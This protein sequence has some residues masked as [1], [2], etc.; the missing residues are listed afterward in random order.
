[1]KRRQLGPIRVENPTD[2]VMRRYLEI[3]VD[4][5][6]SEAELSRGTSAASR[7]AE[8]S[9]VERDAEKCDCACGCKTIVTLG[10]FSPPVTLCMNCRD[11]LV[12]RETDVPVVRR[13]GDGGESPGGE[14]AH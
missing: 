6:V 2:L 14:T 10:R 3:H 7:E 8:Q 9:G 13:C 12:R 5:R 11:H 1:M 4:R